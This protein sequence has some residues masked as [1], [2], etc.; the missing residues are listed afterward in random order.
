MGCSSELANRSISVGDTFAHTPRASELIGAHVPAFAAILGVPH[1]VGAVAVRCSTCP[2]GTEWRCS[3]ANVSAGTAI[4]R[5]ETQIG[6]GSVAAVR[7]PFDAL[8]Y[9]HTGNASPVLVRTRCLT[10]AA[11]SAT[12]VEIVGQVGAIVAATFLTIGSAI[13][14]TRAAVGIGLQIAADPVACRRRTAYEVAAGAPQAA[15]ISLARPA[16]RDALILLRL[17]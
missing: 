6:T 1:Q 14:S 2:V 4:I 15:R 10:P 7:S 5:I 3:R 12:V 13:I 16:S 11:A 8:V 9:T 17:G